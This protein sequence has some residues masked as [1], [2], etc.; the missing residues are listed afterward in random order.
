MVKTPR[1]GSVRV[2]TP[3]R[4]EELRPG[5]FSVGGLSPGGVVSWGLSP[6]I[7]CNRWRCGIVECIRFHCR[8]FHASTFCRTYAILCRHTVCG[9]VCVCL[10]ATFVSC[11]KTNKHNTSSKFLHHRVATPFNFSVPNG[12]AIFRRDSP[13][14]G[15]MQVGEAEIAILSL[16]ACCC[17]YNR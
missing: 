3:S 4:G 14:G 17:L 1:R 9:S 10:S 6:G 11:V 5:V 7:R 13:P 2:E 15:L 8:W 16:Y 12:I